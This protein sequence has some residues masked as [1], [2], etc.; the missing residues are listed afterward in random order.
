MIADFEGWLQNPGGTIIAKGPF[1]IETFRYIKGR[2]NPHYRARIVPTQG[3]LCFAD[4]HPLTAK[5]EGNLQAIVNTMFHK[6]LTAWRE[7]YIEGRPEE[8]ANG[9]G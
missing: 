3:Q 5:T 9:K 1:R 2:G 8:A 7:S 4:G 6:R